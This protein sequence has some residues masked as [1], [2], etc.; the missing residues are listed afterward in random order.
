MAKAEVKDNRDLF[1]LS[2]SPD[3]ATV[4]CAGETLHVI[5]VKERREISPPQL[6][7]AEG[8]IDSLAFSPDGT[9]LAVGT[10]ALAQEGVFLIDAASGTKIRSFGVPGIGY[11]NAYTVAFSLDGKMLAG[12]IDYSNSG[13]G[14]ALWDVETGK[15]VHRLRGLFGNPNCLA[16]SPDGNRLA[17][18]NSDAEVAVWDIT[19]GNLI[20]SNTVGHIH[21]PKKMRFLP[22]D[23]QLATAGDDGTI[24]IWNLADS[25]QVRSMHIEANRGGSAVEIRGMDVSPNG[26]YIA[27]STLLDNSVRLWDATTGREVFRLPGHGRYGGYRGVRF[28]PDNK[29]LA[30]WGDDMHVFL[31]DVASGKADRDYRAQPEGVELPAESEIRD[32][33]DRVAGLGLFGGTFSPDASMLMV[34]LDKTYRFDVASGKELP[35]IEHVPSP[36]TG[37][38]ISPDNRYLLATTW[39]KWNKFIGEDGNEELEPAKNYPVQLHD[40]A[41]NHVTAELELPGELS[42]PIAF[43]SDSRMVA[44]AANDDPHIELRKAPDLA[45]ASRIDLPCRA[46]ALEFSRSGDLLAVSLADCTVL[47]IDLPQ[48]VQASTGADPAPAQEQPTPEA[49]KTPSLAPE[50]PA[51]KAADEPAERDDSKQDSTL[52]TNL[53]LDEALKRMQQTLDKLRSYD[54]YL[55]IEQ[56]WPLKTVV[57]PV[58]DPDRPGI[59]EKYEWQPWAPDETP[60]SEVHKSRQ[61]RSG[62]KRRVEGFG[63]NSGVA[64]SDGKERRT[65]SAPD[66][67]GSRQASIDQPY[68]LTDAYEDFEDY[69]ALPLMHC[70]LAQIIPERPSARIANSDDHGLVVIELPPGEG[71]LFDRF[72]WRIWLDPQHGYLPA[73]WELLYAKD[74][75]SPVLRDRVQIL[76][77]KELGDDAW[78]PVECTRDFYV[79]FSDGEPHSGEIATTIR[80]TVDLTR[81]RWNIDLPDDLFGL[82]F[83]AGTQVFDEQRNQIVITGPGDDGR[84]N[85][86]LLEN[87]KTKLPMGKPEPFSQPAAGDVTEEER[88][89]V[90][91]LKKWF[92]RIKLDK[93]G[94]ASS[95]SM[96]EPGFWAHPTA[97]N[98][99]DEAMPLIGK[100]RHLKTLGLEHT[101]ITD[102]GLAQIKDLVELEGL[103]LENTKITDKGIANLAGL[104]ALKRLR[105][106]NNVLDEKGQL[107]KRVQITDKGLESL[108]ELQNL[109]LLD[110]RGNEITDVGLESLKS[111][112]KLR[113]LSLNQTNVTQ[114]GVQALKDALPNLKSVI[115]GN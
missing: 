5:D 66:K 80:G 95:V 51:P 62:A 54:V 18:T 43:S 103:S 16:F 90:A 7:L 15:L 26:K 71:K 42:G 50:S 87:A 46:E 37:M 91:Q 74:G 64:V 111:L 115:L 81:S 28:T 4:A 104:K 14:I 92:L 32:K 8:S 22:G 88:D 30:S 76:K 53:T 65:L 78:V 70:K 1:P 114:A 6:D 98:V 105:I 24:R 97:P 72:G 100:L 85:Q 86:K 10:R 67:N 112:T 99:Y 38:A 110:L 69:F 36:T 75:K 33:G 52:K 3:G 21:P 48:L 25:R 31:W 108:K 12:P 57:V 109:E 39:G 47:V 77:F 49:P 61:S 96:P 60:K 45:K 82:A 55:D 79:S 13:G 23:H 59:R 40:L 29:Q 17:A 94:R 41:D 83:P 68:E 113:Q 2:I 11:W 73:K 34:A 89:T 58:N 20:G 35:R 27:S 9:K 107:I 102:E 44:L 106:D 101:E 63:D 93:N 19:T 84:D 56:K